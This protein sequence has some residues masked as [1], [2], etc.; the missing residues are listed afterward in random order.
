MNHVDRIKSNLA[1]AA[2]KWRLG[3]RDVHELEQI[4]SALDEAS[5]TVSKELKHKLETPREFQFKSVFGSGNYAYLRE[6]D[7]KDGT[8]YLG[9]FVAGLDH[10]NTAVNLDEI[11]Q[12][13]DLIREDR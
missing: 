12:A 8:W 4:L 6:D 11:R 2:D 10:G 5:V 7:T 3:G 13:L 9:S 1:N